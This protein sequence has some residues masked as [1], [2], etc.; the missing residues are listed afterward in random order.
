M[1]TDYRGNGS[2]LNYTGDIDILLLESDF[3]DYIESNITSELCRD[4]LITA[5]CATLYPVC[6]ENGTVQL[7]CPEQCEDVLND[8]CMQ[9][10]AD[11]VEY[12]NEWI[13]DPVVNFTLNCS[14]SLNFAELYLESTVCYDD[15][16]LL[17]LLDDD[18]NNSTGNS[19]SV[20]TST[21]TPTPTPT[22]MPTTQVP[23]PNK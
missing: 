20:P 10:A 16:C 7:L 23:I 5:V 17:I 14:N 8:M 6:T 13:G 2:Y 11:V 15:N 12:I 3:V 19:T 18:S 4:Y 1:C 9:E 22:V 21:P